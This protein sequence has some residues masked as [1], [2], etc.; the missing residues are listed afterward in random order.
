[1]ELGD[2]EGAG[3][4]PLKAEPSAKDSGFRRPARST[5]TSAEKAASGGRAPAPIFHPLAYRSV[6][7][8]W[9]IAWR[10][11]WGQRANELEETGLSWRDAET[12]AFVELWHKVQQEGQAGQPPTADPAPSTDDA[13]SSRAPATVVDVES[14]SVDSSPASAD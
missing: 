9:P 6:V 10:E 8:D 2:E 1:M 3:G 4:D 13:T 5:G 7:A 12:Q 14:S 11:Q